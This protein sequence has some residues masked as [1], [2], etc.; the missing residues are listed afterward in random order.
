MA[1][2]LVLSY[3]FRVDYNNARLGTVNADTDTYKAEQINAFIK[4]E[5][6]ERP[7]FPSFGIEDPVFK[8]FDIAEFVDSFLEFYKSQHI[9]IEEVEVSQ[10]N[11]V[12]QDVAVRFK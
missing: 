3:P 4:T 8:G 6:Q 1:G 9:A 5:K 7:L 2:Q 12:L 10:K 11:G